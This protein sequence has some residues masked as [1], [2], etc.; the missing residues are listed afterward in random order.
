MS[1]KLWFLGDLEEI[2]DVHKEKFGTGE[3]S[4]YNL[5]FFSLHVFIAEKYIEREKILNDMKA[6]YDEEK[7]IVNPI[8]FTLPSKKQQDGTLEFGLLK[9]E[10]V[11]KMHPIREKNHKLNEEIIILQDFMRFVYSIDPKKSNVFQEKFLS[12]LENLFEKWWEEQIVLQTKKA[13]VIEAIG[14]TEKS[15]QKDIISEHEK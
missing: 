4:W 13:K 2:I 15:E 12:Q 6:I 5:F 3:N 11:K 9:D 14:P 1:A 8:G 7:P 10:N